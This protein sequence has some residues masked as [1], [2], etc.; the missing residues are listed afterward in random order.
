MQNQDIEN[1]YGIVVPESLNIDSAILERD[2]NRAEKM[3]M[4]VS[5]YDHFD[6]YDSAKRLLKTTIDHDFDIREGRVLN[7]GIQ[8]CSIVSFA[9]GAVKELIDPLDNLV[10]AL[11]K[12]GVQCY[13]ISPKAKDCDDWKEVGLYNGVSQNI[14]FEDNSFSTLLAL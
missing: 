3:G 6:I 1:G 14:P 10:I 5:K 7:V 12:I 8:T 11:R 2:L 4:L 13:G 9:S